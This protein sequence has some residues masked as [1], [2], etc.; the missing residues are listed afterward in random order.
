MTAPAGPLGLDDIAELAEL[1]QFLDA[2]LACDH[3]YLDQSLIRFVGH[4]AYNLNRLREDLNRFAALLD[5]AP[6][7]SPLTA[8]QPAPDPTNAPF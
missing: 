8:R 7:T 5:A 3:E 4:D 6:D 1:V 2:W